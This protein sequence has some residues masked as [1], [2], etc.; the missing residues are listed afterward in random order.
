MLTIFLNYRHLCN[1]LQSL[2][3]KTR[4][5][6]GSY[7]K[8]FRNYIHL[9]F[10]II[11]AGL[12]SKM[13]VT[14]NRLKKILLTTKYNVSLFQVNGSYKKQTVIGHVSSLSL[15]L[16]KGADHVQNKMQSGPDFMPQVKTLFKSPQYSKPP[17]F[18]MFPLL[19][20]QTL[21]RC[22]LIDEGE[23]PCVWDERWE[24]EWREALSFHSAHSQ[25]DLTHR[26]HTAILG[27]LSL[28]FNS[29]LSH[30]HT[31]T[32][33]SSSRLSSQERQRCW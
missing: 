32:A 20:I 28:G 1:K 3:F 2:L 17:G 15:F 27:H 25:T 21:C 33:A 8:A 30:T 6:W 5:E 9:N 16:Y 24:R 14:V 12:H 22:C 4:P 29:S 26:G 18:R 7:S 31:H 13:G 11:F 10:D 23:W 19:R